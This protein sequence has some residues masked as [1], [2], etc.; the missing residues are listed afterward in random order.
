MS[1]RRRSITVHGMHDESLADLE[2]NDEFFFG[3]EAEGDSESDKS[4]DSSDD[5]PPAQRIYHSLGAASAACVSSDM[6]ELETISDA[7]E[8]F[9]SESE[10]DNSKVRTAA[11][12]VERAEQTSALVAS[13][14]E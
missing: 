1:A 2:S 9:L 11:T 12:T 4:D 7:E 6:P 14:S 10:D 13:G 8:V 5:E 3:N